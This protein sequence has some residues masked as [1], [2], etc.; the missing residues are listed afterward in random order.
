VIQAM[1]GEMRGDA[2][3]IKEL[4]EE[5][6]KLTPGLVNDRRSE[7]IRAELDFYAASQ[8]ARY[9]RALVWATVALVVATVG[10][11]VVTVL[12]ALMVGQP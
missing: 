1:E 11:I 3:R 4:L 5:L 10:L 6:R 9:A 2:K 7:V 12:S 8:Q